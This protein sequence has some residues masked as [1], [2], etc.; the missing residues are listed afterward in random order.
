MLVQVSE[1]GD[2]DDDHDYAE[3]DEP[4]AWGEERPVVGRVAFEEGDFGKYEEYC[5]L[6]LATGF[7]TGDSTTGRGG[8][9]LTAHT[10]C[11]KMGD[12]VEEEEFRDDKGFDQH[13]EAGGDDGEE[14]DYIQHTED[15][16]DDVAWT[17]Q[18]SVEERHY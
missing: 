6:S 7:S 14:G 5:S 16:E 2:A 3:G 13:D 9:E 15:V 8:R 11:D 1:N 12:A 10:A 17:S 4:V 18:G